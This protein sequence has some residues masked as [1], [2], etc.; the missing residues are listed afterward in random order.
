MHQLPGL[1]LENSQVPVPCLG[2]GREG[3]GSPEGAGS[4]NTE[5]YMEMGQIRLAMRH[6]ASV[7]NIAN[8]VP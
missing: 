6:A 5:I 3:V 4:S 2:V 1:A 8:V 7:L